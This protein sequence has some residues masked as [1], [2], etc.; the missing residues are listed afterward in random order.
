MNAAKKSAPRRRPGPKRP[1]RPPKLTVH[2]DIGAL[3]RTKK[4]TSNDGARK[5][6][7]KRT[8]TNA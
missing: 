8:G 2:G 4:G 3:T 1:Y 5:P 7:T 6:R